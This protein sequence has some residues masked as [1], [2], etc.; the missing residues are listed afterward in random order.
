MGAGDVWGA[1]AE[2]QPWGCEMAAPWRLEPPMKEK[3]NTSERPVRR[4]SVI[5]KDLT[6]LSIIDNMLVKQGVS[7]SCP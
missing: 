5:V 4:S 2:T 7:V 1:G 6:M 3:K